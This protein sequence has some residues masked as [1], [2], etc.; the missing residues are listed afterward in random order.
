VQRALK[1]NEG[2]LGPGIPYGLI[3]NSGQPPGTS[4]RGWVSKAESN[5]ELF[6]RLGLE[7][8]AQNIFQTWEPSPTHVLPEWGDTLTGVVAHFF[9]HQALPLPPRTSPAPFGR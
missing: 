7:A 1:V 3:R 5:M 9:D 8:P 6:D 4:D 2:L